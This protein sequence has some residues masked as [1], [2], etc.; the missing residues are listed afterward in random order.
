MEETSFHV[1]KQTEV[2]ISLYN[3]GTIT[4]DSLLDLDDTVFLLLLAC[5]RLSSSDTIGQVKI[6][7]DIQSQTRKRDALIGY[8]NNLA[9]AV[10]TPLIYVNSHLRC[11]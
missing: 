5:F 6:N 11:K 8:K 4:L 10:L 3:V 9:P 2:F 7:V 1:P